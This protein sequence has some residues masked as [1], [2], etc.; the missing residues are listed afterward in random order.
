[1]L[2]VCLSHFGLEY[3]RL[4]GDTP[5]RDELHHR[6]YRLAD[7]HADHRARADRPATL[8]REGSLSVSIK[9]GFITD[10][11]GVSVLVGLFFLRNVGPVIADPGVW[12]GVRHLLVGTFPDAGPNNFP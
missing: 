11:V 10:V 7:L 8:P 3:F 4:M 6:T 2:F 5:A 12:S 1:M 9:L